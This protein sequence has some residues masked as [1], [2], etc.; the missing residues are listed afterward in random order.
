MTWGTPK[1]DILVTRKACATTDAVILGKTGC[2]PSSG[3]IYKSEN[4]DLDSRMN[5]KDLSL[6][7]T[8]QQYQC[9][10]FRNCLTE[11]QNLKLNHECDF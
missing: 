4:S 3:S 7:V 1:R 11:G 8:D 2:H 5:S 10:P 6:V 9:V